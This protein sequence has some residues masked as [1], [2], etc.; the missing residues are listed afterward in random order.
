MM[1]T[2]DALQPE[3]AYEVDGELMSAEQYEQHMRQKVESLYGSFAR[4]RD[5]W[6][7]HRAQSGVE[8]QWRRASSL[9]FGRREDER[10]S[11]LER[12]LREGP[13]PK[14]SAEPLRSKVVVNIV[15][16]K[17]DQAVARLCEILFPVDDQNWGIKPTPKPQLSDR[18]GNQ[19]PTVD[20]NTGQP[21]GATAD[22]EARVVIEEAKKR[23]E[24]MQR[25]IADSLTECA[26]NGESRKLIE[27]GVRLGGGVIK[28]PF[29]AYQTSKVW[30]TEGGVSELVINQDIVPSSRRIDLWDIFFDPACGNDHQRGRG[31]W[32]RRMVT[33]KELRALV[34]LPG[35]DSDAI[36]RVLREQPR[37][38]RIAEQRVNREVIK[39]DAYELWEYHGEIEPDEMECLTRNTG[40]PLEDVSFGVLI[41]VNDLVIGALD[42]WSVDKT[43]PYD[44]WNWRKADDH[45][46][47]H[48]LPDELEDQQRVVNSAWRMVMDNGR[49]SLGGQVVMKKGKIIPQDGNMA[50]TPNKVWLASEDLEDVTKAFA[51]FEFNSHLQELLMIAKTAMEFADMESSMPQILGGNAQQG[52]GSGAPETLGGMVLMFNNASAVLRQRVKLYDDSITRPHIGRYYDWKMANDPDESIKGDFEV[53]A[54]GSTALI[55]RDIQNQA[56]INLANITNNPRYTPHLKEREEL[57]AILKAFKINPEEVMKSEDQVKQDMEAAAQN[58]PQDPRIVSAQT[59]LQVKQLDIQD[60]QQQRAF[61]QQRNDAEF[62][63]RHQNLI[64]NA[65]REQSEAEQASVDSQLTRELALAKMGQD[66]ALTREQIAAKNRIE[67]IKITDGRERFNAEAAL[68]MRTGQGI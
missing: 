26:Y 21:T 33:R 34:G 28:G 65:M 25:S 2:T 43:V 24:A 22:S 53:D 59:Q 57:K 3:M 10:D 44:I 39:E 68:R 7:Q 29:P 1:N 5:E 6:V 20:P 17:V 47:G 45:P 13:R 35:Y 48:G 56:L 40:D 67:L 4:M 36:R 19:T 15:R 14:T 38:I 52:A 37:R 11:D 31:V 8:R 30:R 42:S 49:T 23:C 63:F 55:E 64:Y 54:R 66:G 18:L 61:E 32:E 27:D 46:Y 62:K 9:Y 12:T 41:M 58:P 16:P 60:K 50:I 51:T